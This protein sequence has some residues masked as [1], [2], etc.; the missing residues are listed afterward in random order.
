MEVFALKENILFLVSSN[1]KNFK[2]CRLTLNA[3]M[4][5]PLADHFTYRRKSWKNVGIKLVQCRHFSEGLQKYCLTRQNKVSEKL[6]PSPVTALFLSKG[7][8]VPQSSDIFNSVH[9]SQ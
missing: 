9:Y 3:Q 5:I 4:L 1:F 8:F 6:K 2:I 7:R